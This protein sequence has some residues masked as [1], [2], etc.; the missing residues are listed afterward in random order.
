MK[1]FGW[2]LVIN[3][4]YK[5]LG[6]VDIDSLIEFS[7]Y[8]IC[9]NTVNF[10]WQ[11]TH[12]RIQ[13]QVITT[14]HDS[15][16][17]AAFMKIHALIHSPFE[18]TIFLDADTVANWNIDELV[19]I[20][21]SEDWHCP[22]LHRHPVPQLTVSSNILS[23]FG[24][25]APCL[26]YSQSNMIMV[27]PQ[28]RNRLR[29]FEDRLERIIEYNGGRDKQPGYE[30]QYLNAFLWMTHFRYQLMFCSPVEGSFATYMEGLHRLMER[31]YPLYPVTWHMFHGEKDP[32]RARSM[33]E[34]LLKTGSDFQ[35]T[36]PIRCA[37]A[38]LL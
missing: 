19:D 3:E 23:E 5:P 8:D 22:I 37:Q 35:S 36:H 12:G 6:Q 18:W 29:H 14:E 33:F 34:E 9:V 1:D 26:P 15:P 38:R 32:I 16:A 30:E 4:N 2:T 28:A 17:T 13:S 20:C 25:P 11:W 21:I 10:E 31:F 7:D 27:A 24:N